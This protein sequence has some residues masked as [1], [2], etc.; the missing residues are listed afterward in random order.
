MVVENFPPPPSSVQQ[1]RL[2]KLVQENNKMLKKMRRGQ[3]ID[4]VMRIVYWLILI[5]IA[6][7]SFYYLQPWIQQMTEMYSSIVQS[8]GQPGEVGI[9]GFSLDDIMKFIPGFDV[10]EPH[11]ATTTN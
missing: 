3:T 2:M 4:R 1:E 11:T 6:V 7:G 10:V 9:P 8:I 5:G